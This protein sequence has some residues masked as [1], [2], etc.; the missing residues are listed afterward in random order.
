MMK[1]KLTILNAKA[2]NDFTVD[3]LLNNGKSFVFDIKP[4]L[5][6]NGLKKLRQLAF[7]KQVKYADDLLFWDD[8]HDFPLHCMDIKIE[9]K[10]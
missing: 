5:K 1:K 9:D 10:K 7:F 4:Y 6:G 2:N 8:M 3:I